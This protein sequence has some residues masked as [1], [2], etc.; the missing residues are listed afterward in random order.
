M[1]VGTRYWN[2]PARYSQQNNN[3]EEE[4]LRIQLAEA[5]KKYGFEIKSATH[6]EFCGPTAA[7]NAHDATSLPYTLKLPGGYVAQTESLLTAVFRDPANYKLW[8]AAV[9]DSWFDPAVTPA[10]RVLACYPAA[11]KLAFGWRAEFSYAKPTWA[12]VCARLKQNKAL[13]VCLREP[14]HY[15]AL[16][17]HDS[18][19]NE[20]IFNDPWNFRGGVH[21]F[22]R[23]LSYGEWST[24]VKEGVLAVWGS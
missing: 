6:L 13:V 24:N 21:G 22:N 5:S 18:A 2:D 4:A 8:K 7:I 3:P 9:P 14:S 1:I 11:L 12:Q 10:N 23:R 20:L 17:A 15:I 16:K 19:T